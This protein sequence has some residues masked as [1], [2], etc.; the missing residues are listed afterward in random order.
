MLTVDVI[1]HL[2]R[3]T[4]ASATLWVAYSGGLDSR[5]LLQLLADCRAQ[6]SSG[7]GLQAIHVN[8]GLHPE[9]DHWQHHCEQ[10]CSRLAIPLM[11]ERLQIDAD[12]GNLE[13]R[14]RSLRYEAFRRH[15]KPGDILLMAHHQDDQVETMLY[16]LMRGRGVA[17]L[18]GMPAERRLGAGMLQRPLLHFPRQSLLDFARQRTLDW[19][20]DPSNTDTDFDRNYLRHQVM[21]VLEDRWPGFR[22]VWQRSAGLLAEAGQCQDLVAAQDLQSLLTE[23]SHC[24]QLTP[25]RA[26]DDYR[27]RNVLRYWLTELSRQWQVPPPDNVSLQR[28]VSEVLTAAEDARPLVGWPKKANLMQIRRF[29]DWL[30]ALRPFSEAV[31]AALVWPDQAPLVINAELGSLHWEPT[32][33]PGIDPG[34]L[35]PLQVRFRHGGESARP[36]GRRT[37]PLKKLYQDYAV[38]P[39]LRDRVPLIYAG[40]ELLAAADIFVSDGWLQSRGENLHRICW[41]R[42]LLH[43]GY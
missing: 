8:H 25:L 2:W 16:S 14:A 9:T 20:D 4:P 35:P 17:A 11:V 41:Q 39:W 13:A 29:G 19:I 42:S 24:L 5:V 33:G 10:T 37:R 18:A 26:L 32:S 7:P 21:P 27:Q 31:P 43:C 36:A 28:I 38:P 34:S 3:K 23:Y 15:L 30:Y 1:D 22:A 12:T 6:S 40:D